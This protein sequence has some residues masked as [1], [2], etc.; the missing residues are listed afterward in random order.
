MHAVNEKNNKKK[1][2]NKLIL[3]QLASG[4]NVGDKVVEGGNLQ[5]LVSMITIAFCGLR[6]TSGSSVLSV[7]VKVSSFSTRLSAMIL[8]FT[9]RVM[10]SST[11]LRFLL[12][13]KVTSI[14]IKL[15]RTSL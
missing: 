2:K 3:Q 8:I 7:T 9:Q 5:S 6:T 15:A 11:C 4:D 14:V 10:P 13:P 12:P 1:N